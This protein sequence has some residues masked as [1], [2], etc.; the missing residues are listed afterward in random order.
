MAQFLREQFNLIYDTGYVAPLFRLI[1]IVVVGL[2]VMMLIDSALKRVRM[3]I[4]PGDDLGLRRVEQRAETLRHIVRSISKVVLF[5]I[6]A[7]TITSELGFNMGPILGTA[8]IIGVAIGFGA[9]SLVKDF[10]AG[11]FILLEDQFGVGDV[12]RV[13]EQAGVVERMTL[14]VTVLR[15]I[16]GQV[17]VI[18]NGSIQTVTV[19]TKDWSRALVDVTVAYTEKVDK[20]C[21]ILEKVADQLH[22]DWPD[23]VVERPQVL[24]VEELG[25]D[26]VKIRLIAK[27][28]PLKQ[29]EVMREWRKRIKEEFDRQGVEIPFPRKTVWFQ[30]PGLEEEMQAKQKTR[31]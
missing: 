28:P 1:W 9:Q 29:W 4:P 15:N 25:T 2:M 7:L 16:E 8:G 12:V 3:L 13:G 20:V 19:M 23:R 24:G 18:P 17:H 14:R 11:F 31:P 21:Q 27:T 26:G 5:A 6:V 10:I 30:I 22:R